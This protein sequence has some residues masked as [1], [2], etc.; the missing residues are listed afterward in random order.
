M[1]G[2]LLPK[3]PWLADWLIAAALRR[4]GSERE[5]EP[6]DDGL[7]VAAHRTAAAIA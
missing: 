3:N 5:L 7:E 2:P 6:L 4:H 1:H